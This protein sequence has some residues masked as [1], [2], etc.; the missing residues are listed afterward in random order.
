MPGMDI[1]RS[2]LSTNAPGRGTDEP[3]GDRERDEKVWL[4]E[5]GDEGIADEGDEEDDE[6]FDDSDDMEEADD[7]DE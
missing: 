2:D 6:V 1:K 5:R 3:V 7:A 4:P